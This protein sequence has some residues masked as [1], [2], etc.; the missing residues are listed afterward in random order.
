MKFTVVAV[1]LACCQ[2]TSAFPR[3]VLLV[4]HRCEQRSSTSTVL[5][6]KGFKVQPQPRRHNNARIPT[7]TKWCSIQDMIDSEAAM[8]N[9]FSSMRRWTL[10]R[11]IAV[12]TSCQAMEAFG[13]DIEYGCVIDFHE[14]SKPWKRL[15][16]IRISRIN[17]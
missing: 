3:L 9:F 2:T 8:Q 15:Q 6:I 7:E 12:D 16:A 5:C 11:S 14:S 4:H 13:N 1:I 10:F 17:K